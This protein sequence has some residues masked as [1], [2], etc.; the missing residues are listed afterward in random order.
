VDYGGPQRGTYEIS[1]R[2]KVVFFSTSP[3]VGSDPAVRVFQSKVV[4]HR[5][6]EL[7]LAAEIALS[8]LNRCVPKQKPNLLKFSAD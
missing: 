8:R 7:L 3:R 4:V 5:F 1:A 2:L 6:A